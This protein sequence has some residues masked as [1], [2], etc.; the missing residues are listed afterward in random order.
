MYHRIMS[1]GESVSRNLK[2]FAAEGFV[3]GDPATG[4]RFSPRDS[5]K[6]RFAADLLKAYRERRVS[7]IEAIYKAP[8]DPVQQFADAFK[9]RKDKP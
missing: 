5:D 9:L 7:V 4:Y 1:S 8:V 6:G 3:A 2:Y